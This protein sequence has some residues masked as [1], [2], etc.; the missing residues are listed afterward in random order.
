ML[1]RAGEPDARTLAF[2]QLMHQ[3]STEKVRLAATA[4]DLVRRRAA[5]AGNA[6]RPGGP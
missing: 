1:S 5:V 6:S 2:R 3:L 4:G